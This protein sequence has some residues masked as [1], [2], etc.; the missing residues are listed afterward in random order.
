MYRIASNRDRPLPS[1]LIIG[2]YKCGTTSLFDFLCRHPQVSRPDE[3]EINFFTRHFDK[4]PGWYRSHFPNI[5]P[6]RR[7]IPENPSGLIT[8]EAT[9]A[10]LPDA[11][12]AANLATTLPN[13]K[14]IVLLRW[15][16]ERTISHYFFRAS[17][18]AN[19]EAFQHAIRTEI[20]AISGHEDQL[21]KRCNGALRQDTDRATEF[22]LK[23]VY[24]YQL[25]NWFRVFPRD[26]VL[27]LRAEDLFHRPGGTCDRICAFVGIEPHAL[28]TFPVARKGRK[29]AIDSDISAELDAYFA[30]HNEALYELLGERLWE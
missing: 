9:P 26:Q 4:G 29:L 30:P 3:K 12:A 6:N 7:L 24:V 15:P 10:Y 14:L 11:R 27:V 25:L 5:P 18:G 22:V 20:A 19:E 8:F 23:S 13:A 1:F 21:L 28:G 16:T 17:Y 2:A